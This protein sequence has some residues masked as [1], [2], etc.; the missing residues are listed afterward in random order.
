MWVNKLTILLAVAVFFIIAIYNPASAREITVDNSGSGADFQS[1]QEAINNSLSGDLILVYPGF[2]NESVDIE[3]QNIS[4][5]SKS[6]N[7]EDTTVRAFNVSANNTTVSGLSIQEQLNLQ[8]PVN[9]AWYDKIENCTVK[10][11]ILGSGIGADEC[12][13]STIEKN[14]ILSSG[15]FILGPEGD[16]DFTVSDNLIINGNIDVSH[17]QFQCV[18]LNNTLLKGGIGVG[19]GSGYT[20]LGNYV[21]NGMYNGYG[22]LFSESSS[23]K[24]ENN[25]V[26]N[27]T[28]GIFLTRLSWSNIV[29][30][31]TLMFN[32]KGIYVDS[33]D[34]LFLNNTISKNN[35]GILVGGTTIDQTGG[36]SLL[37]NTISNNNI[38][39]SFE[40]DSSGN[41]VTNNRVELNE[42]YGV[43]IN[44]VYYLMSYD[45]NNRFY[46]NMF[47]NTN[48]FFNDTGNYT[49]NYYVAKATNISSRKISV[50]LNTTKTSGNN[51]AGGSYFGGN[52]WVKP[53]GTG[54]S[55]TCN[56]WDLDG[57][58]DSIYMVSAYDI[59]YLPLVSMS[60]ARQS[61][62]P[63]A[64]FRANTT[65]GY[66][67]LS[68][69]FTDFSQNA[70]FRTWDFEND[71]IIDSTDKVPVHVYPV[72]GTYT[73]NLTVSNANG[74]SSKLYPVT[75]SNRPQYI[76]RETQITTNKSNQVKPAI[77]GD[78]IV[79]LD[80]RN[81]WE[82]YNIYIYDLSTSRETQIST[83]VSHYDYDIRP[84]IYDDRIV[85]KAH[86]NNNGTWEN[87]G[88]RVYNLSTSKE[89][90]ITKS[91]SASDPAIYGDRVVWTDARN[92]NG[93]IY[94]YNLSTD[95]ETRITADESNQDHP[96][97]YGDRIVWQDSRNG[98]DYNLTD[99]Y[100]YDLSTSTETRITADD[101][102]QY[103]PAIYED[104]I[105]WWDSRNGGWNL[106]MYDLSTSKETQITTSKGYQ[107]NHA[108][109]GDRIVWVDGR[110]RNADI[111]M[112]DLSTHTEVQITSNNSEQSDPAIYGDRIVWTDRRNEYTL[113]AVPDIISGDIYTCTVSGIEP[114]IK[115]PVADF[116]ANITSGNAPL[117]VLFT[118]NSTG[119]PIF[120]H[121]DF[122]DGI[123][124]KHALNSTHTFTEPGSYDVSL[125]VT[126]EN[127]SN[128]WIIPG[129]ITVSKSK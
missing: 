26:V 82:Y 105:V 11:N 114:S 70:T 34:N 18:L 39:I 12:Y 55:Q 27:C 121:W 75:A 30:N 113:D 64:D 40:D 36:S 24:I 72:S 22:I 83:E 62:F 56:D 3:T 119:A 89:T 52:L 57:I 54:F 128:T 68:V 100:M 9:D 20:I 79:F 129:Y 112:Y 81:R 71:G 42:Q 4:I 97:I 104:K 88:I 46:N 84:V 67:P 101:S 110:N 31:N 76:L 25:T 120:W 78:K 107:G 44:H 116:F 127:G 21:S 122:G 115:T 58:G 49:G 98:E 6:E 63:V 108:I 96:A 14:V 91:A 29:Y 86:R 33:G 66:V 1:I 23:S 47:N 43:Y 19:E 38:G 32:D 111:Y 60:R 94:M 35:I 8:S 37:N 93:D 16:S 74:T 5:C 123:N 61:V 103:S 106:Y 102:G 73:V 10:N 28:N 126:N 15:I 87:S 77:Y 99:I 17:G 85:W 117:R 7:P 13:N 69:L 53:D 124:S 118:G 45:G 90:Q 109:Y 50:A 92:G 95:R 125:T 65:G 48:N 41:L 51:I 59:D 2:Y 80:N